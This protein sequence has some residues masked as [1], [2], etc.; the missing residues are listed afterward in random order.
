MQVLQISFDCTHSIN[1]LQQQ[2]EHHHNSIYHSSDK[3]NKQRT[4]NESFQKGKVVQMLTNESY[5][6]SITT[7]CV[8]HNLPY[9][10]VKWDGF[11]NHKNLLHP[12]MGSKIKQISQNAFKQELDKEYKKCKLALIEHLASVLRKLSF[13]ADCWTSHNLIP[14]TRLTY[15]YILSAWEM[16]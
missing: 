5:R 9:T 1:A 6:K 13:I 8:K 15:H 11:H 4:I 3:S 7:M 16:E 14:F 12:N 10:F 2:L